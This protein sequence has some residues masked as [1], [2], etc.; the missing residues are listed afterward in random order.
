MFP[1]VS[2][3][4]LDDKKNLKDIAEFYNHL[5]MYVSWRDLDSNIILANDKE[6]K[7]MGFYS[8]QDIISLLNPIVLSHEVILT[9][10]IY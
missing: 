8:Y 10:Y 2:F 9:G 4:H 3:E 5:P 1:K 6:A 7:A